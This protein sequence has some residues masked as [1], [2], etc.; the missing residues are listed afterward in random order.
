VR[1][2]LGF[3]VGKTYGVF[4]EGLRNL[5]TWRFFESKEPKYFFFEVLI[6]RD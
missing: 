1:I 6:M 5:E 4:G 2:S 3:R